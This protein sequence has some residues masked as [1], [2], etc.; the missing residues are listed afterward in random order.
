MKDLRK[1]VV[2][3][4]LSGKIE[5]SLITVIEEV[6]G[7]TVIFELTPEELSALS[8]TEGGNLTLLES[9]FDDPLFAEEYYSQGMMIFEFEGGSIPFDI[10]AEE[11][12]GKI[13]I[14]QGEGLGYPINGINLLAGEGERSWA[15]FPLQSDL[16]YLS[17]FGVNLCT[18]IPLLNGNGIFRVKVRRVIEK[19]G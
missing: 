6:I 2:N 13:Y 1:A 10:G 7:D 15:L 17:Q 9:L 19:F 18:D 8:I 3:A 4:N 14:K 12:G 16:D 11:E 5:K